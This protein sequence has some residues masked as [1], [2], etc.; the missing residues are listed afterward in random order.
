MPNNA[1]HRDPKW[2]PFLGPLIQLVI[3]L[4]RLLT[5]T[6]LLRFGKDLQVKIIF[7]MFQIFFWLSE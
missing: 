7:T 5:D 2:N 4:S 3:T 6:L 1:I